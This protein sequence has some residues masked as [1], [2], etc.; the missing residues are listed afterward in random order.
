MHTPAVK[1]ADTDLKQDLKLV[2]ILLTSSEIRRI[3]KRSPPEQ[4]P[5]TGLALV[6]L[7]DC[8]PPK[9]L[10]KTLVGSKDTAMG[11]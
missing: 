11:F 9:H 1:G 4:C 8:P 5:Y 2:V 6:A 7:S 10:F 3:T